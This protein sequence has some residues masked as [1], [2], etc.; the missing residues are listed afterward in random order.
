MHCPNPDCQAHGMVNRQ[1]AVV[2]IVDKLGRMLADDEVLQ[3]LVNAACAE[4]GE[5]DQEAMQKA[6]AEI[7]K[8]IAKVTAKISG[9]QDMFGEGTDRDQAETK[10]KVR[11]AQL[12]RDALERER[13][14]LCH[15]ITTIAKPYAART[16][17]WPC[18]S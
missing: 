14:I 1:D 4:R 15:G 3:D 7:D 13:L 17:S 10:A 2:A 18:C 11:A 9:L 6:I 5:V 8:K 16:R 12:E